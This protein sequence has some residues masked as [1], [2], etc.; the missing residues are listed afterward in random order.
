MLNPGL[1]QF[2]QTSY[3]VS[4]SAET[5]SIQVRRTGDLS[6]P[7]TVDYLTTSSAAAD[8][9]V[10][11][12][13]ANERRDFEKVIGTL[14]FAPGEAQKSFDIPIIDDTYSGGAD[15][16]A[17][18]T[19]NIIL[20]N[21]EGAA[22][23]G[24]GAAVVTITDNDSTN[25]ANPLDN[26]DARFVVKQHY[27][28]F[29]GRYPDQAGWDFWTND[30]TSCGTNQGCLEVKRINVSASF[31]LSI[32][33]KE[34]GYLVERIYKTAYGDAA[35]TSTLG[36]TN[37][38]PVPIVRFDEFL[39]DT[40]QIGQGVIVNRTGW[41]Q[42]LEN[43][44][45]AFTWRFVQRSRFLNAYPISLTVA[46]FVDALFANAGVT[47]SSAERQAA[48]DEFAGA[49]PADINA[50]SRVLR[51]VAENASLVQ[52]EFN[53][54]FVLMEYFGYL[55]RNPN[56]LPDAD[57]TGYDFWLRKLNQFNGNFIEAEMVKAFLSS[58]EYRRR[59]AAN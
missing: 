55:R 20:N 40:S 44:K 51:R 6:G 28:D 13:T 45:Q 37:Q 5:L 29:L 11:A 22:V 33:F 4:E 16:G 58:F 32:E 27:Y 24:V 19:F 48:I 54:A 25:G 9:G 57:H 38:L 2:S 41:E 53:R 50:R 1:L 3:T 46:Q 34:T 21:A 52:K 39:A 12:G 31:Y 47:P 15:E 49:N 42:L 23:A 8:F 18:E 17:Q 10:T 36:G 43:N 56:D 26:A 7:A 30:I 14:Y 59:F 35:G